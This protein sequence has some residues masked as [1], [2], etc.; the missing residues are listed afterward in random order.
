MAYDKKY[1]EIDDFIL[2]F[3]KGQEDRT[4]QG[5]DDLLVYV[6]ERTNILENSINDVMKNEQ[7]ILSLANSWSNVGSSFGLARVNMVNGI[8][9]LSGL[10]SGG[11]VGSTIATLPSQYRFTQ[12]V[13][14]FSVA[15]RATST[16]TTV[17]ITSSG[18]VKLL[19]GDTVN[20]D[21][22]SITYIKD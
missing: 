6:D 21:L 8:V 19:A 13:K 9:N 3:D 7:H 22:S 17:E 20:V 11:E 18:A 2:D 14:R 4:E 16:V 1:P 15:S 10:I 5:F 12:G